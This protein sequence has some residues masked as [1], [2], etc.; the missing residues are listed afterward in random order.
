MVL[1]AIA[2]IAAV[3]AV[4][5]GALV[6][7]SSDTRDAHVTTESPTTAVPGPAA[8][9]H[10]VAAR[11]KAADLLRAVPIDSGWTET[12][13]P[14]APILA[15]AASTP[16]TPNLI[17]MARL[18][19][20]PEPWTDVDAWLAD[21]PPADLESSGT[22]S[23]GDRTGP[24]S[25]TLTYAVP[26]LPPSDD[27]FQAVEITTAP[28][29]TG[30]TGIRIDAGVIWIPT[31]SAGELVPASAARAVVTATQNRLILAQ[32]TIDDDARAQAL[33]A[34]VNALEPDVGGVR[35]CPNDVGLRLT[36]VFTGPAG[37]PP[38]TVVTGTCG[39]STFQ[40]GGQDGPALQT[41][42]LANQEAQLLD[43]TLDQLE[44]RA[45]AGSIQSVPADPTTTAP[46]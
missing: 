1:V 33:A 20:T 38:V 25:R 14:P 27:H 46:G 6:L 40:I 42:D 30:G 3:V 29:A 41:G 43:T 18:Y 36:V 16:A 2:A 17:D 11:T 45:L 12:S 4:G 39:T 37:T 24:T 19:T 26:P 44:S 13:T 5:A 35:N 28:L 23:S 8:D 34:T 21:H 32:R 31:R 15:H 22:G 9:P 10:E 7:R